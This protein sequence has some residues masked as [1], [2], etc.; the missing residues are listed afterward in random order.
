MARRGV[1][2]A[3]PPPPVVPG[4]PLTDA[5]AGLLLLAEATVEVAG[6]VAD[7]LVLERSPAHGCSGESV[8]VN[9]STEH[10]L[11][12]PPTRRFR[13]RRYL[14]ELF[15][16]VVDPIH[17]VDGSI[18]GHRHAPRLVEFAGAG[19]L[20]APLRD[21]VA[22]AR[23]LKNPRSGPVRHVNRTRGIDRHR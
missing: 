3:A 19:A 21:E 10:A 12:S 1:M 13:G 2:P 4:P 23:E 18:A 15:D 6:G 11:E 9:M 17:H 22:R 7:D 8:R 5:E 16:A 20:A 14:A